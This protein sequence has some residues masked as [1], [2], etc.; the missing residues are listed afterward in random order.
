MSSKFQDG[1]VPITAAALPRTA[2]SEAVTNP[3][4]LLLYKTVLKCRIL[5]Y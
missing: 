5:F 2:T 1:A 3:I 4:L